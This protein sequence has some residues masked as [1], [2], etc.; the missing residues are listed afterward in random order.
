MKRFLT[1][2]TCEAIHVFTESDDYKAAL[3]DL[4]WNEY[5]WQFAD[6]RYQA[7]RQHNDKHDEWALDDTKETY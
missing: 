3:N 6:S 7:I 4:D 2:A 1:V 5:V